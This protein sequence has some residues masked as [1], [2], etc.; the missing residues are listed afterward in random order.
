MVKKDFYKCTQD[1]DSEDCINNTKEP[2]LAA[3]IDNHIMIN[4][5]LLKENEKL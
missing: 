2:E 3:K 5:D 4:N 1:S